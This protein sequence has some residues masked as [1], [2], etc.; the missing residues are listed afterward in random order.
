MVISYSTAPIYMAFAYIGSLS[1]SLSL[2]I[3]IYIYIYICHE[4][5]METPQI[6]VA[7]IDFTKVI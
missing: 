7:L 3:Y 5:P 1:L 6:M 2:Y 4:K